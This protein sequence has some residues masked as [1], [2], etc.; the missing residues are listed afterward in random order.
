MWVKVLNNTFTQMKFSD[1]MKWQKVK[2]SKSVSL[3]N[4]FFFVVYYYPISCGFQITF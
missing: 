1:K 4:I 3:I 2:F